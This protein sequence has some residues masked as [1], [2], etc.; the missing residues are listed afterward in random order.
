M[1]VNCA[2]SEENLE[3]EQFSEPELLM[4]L[5]VS[6]AQCSLSQG[7]NRSSWFGFVAFFGLRRWQ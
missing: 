4:F 6:F 7:S 2:A 1:S 3:T 5:L